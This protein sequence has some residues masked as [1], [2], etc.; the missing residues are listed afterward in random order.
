L[1]FG[2]TI[3]IGDEIWYEY[4]QWTSEV[5]EEKSLNWR[6][7]TN[8]E[9]LLEGAVVKH[10]LGGSEIF[11]FTDNST[12]EAAF[13][14]GTSQSPLLFELVLR[15]RQLKM[16]H[17][18]ILHVVHVSG[19]RMIDQGADGL[20]RA[21]HYTGAVTGHDIRLWVPLNKGA[22]ER[23]PRLETRICRVTRDLGFT[24]LS[25]EGWFADGHGYGNF[26]WAPAPAAVEVVVEQLGKAR[27]KRAEAM[28]VIIVPRLMTGRWRRHLGRGTDSNF[29]IKN[30]KDAWEI[31]AQ[32]EPLVIFACL[33]YVSHIP[34]LQER[35]ELLAKFQGALPGKD[36]PDIISSGERGR[37]LR[38]L[39]E[40][41]RK[42][43]PLP[44]R[45]V[46]PVL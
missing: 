11:I 5:A 6:E 8:L 17:N 2:A 12:S 42:L 35:Q 39:L 34:R 9:E 16:N 19:K 38:E 7:F 28:H 13:W 21:D 44:R 15:L 24:A 26:L 25:P 3:Q 4:G 45:L 46:P 23:F 22:L 31:L 41:A 30:R 37:L 43:C 18:I 40:L 1:G 29:T 27:L 33:P 32:F 14:K 36:M 20:S 10:K